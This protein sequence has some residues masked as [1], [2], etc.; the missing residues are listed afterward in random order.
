MRNTLCK[1]QSQTSPGFQTQTWRCNTM[2]YTVYILKYILIK[3]RMSHQHLIYPSSPTTLFSTLMKPHSVNFL[4]KKLLK[5]SHSSRK[6]F[7]FFFFLFIFECVFY[8]S[9]CLH[10]SACLLFGRSFTPNNETTQR[11]PELGV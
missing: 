8:R 1:T 5:L 6:G 11:W 10:M 9:V 2:Y 7:L 4:C 3:N